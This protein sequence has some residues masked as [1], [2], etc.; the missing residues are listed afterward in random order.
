MCLLSEHAKENPDAKESIAEM[1]AWRQLD[2]AKHNPYL[3]DFIM[4]QFNGY[5]VL[6]PW[7]VEN[8]QFVEPWSDHQGEF[9]VADPWEYYGREA[10]DVYTDALLRKWAPTVLEEKTRK[11]IQKRTLKDVEAGD[12]IRYKGSS[13]AYS[14]DYEVVRESNTCINPTQAT[15]CGGSLCIVEFMNDDTPMFIPLNSL[16][17]AEWEVLD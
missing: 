5:Q 16:K 10:M 1:W 17:N 3:D 7:I 2:I 13:W 9:A 15:K 12:T 4:F 6:D 11:P 14:G 8:A